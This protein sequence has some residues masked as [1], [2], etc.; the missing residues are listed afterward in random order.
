MVMLSVGISVTGLQL[1]QT[2]KAFAW[3]GV[4]SGIMG[5]SSALGG[6]PIGLS[7]RNDN[8]DAYRATVSGFLSIGAMMSIIGLGIMGRLNT[9]NLLAGASLLPGLLAG[10]A[11]AIPLSKTLRKIPLRPMAQIVSVFAAIAVIAR[12][13]PN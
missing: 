5:I 13:W 12:N 1:P 10:F 11:L 9:P 6:V 3:V 2:P 7:Y 4:L 8:P